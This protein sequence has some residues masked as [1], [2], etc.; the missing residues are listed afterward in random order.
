MK[1]RAVTVRPATLDDVAGIHQAHARCRNPWADPTECALYVNHRLLRGFLIDV[2]VIRGQVVGHAE[3]TLCKE[4]AGR[5]LY[6]GLIQ[7]HREHRGY[8]VGRAMMEA[9]ERHAQ[10]NR[11]PRIVTLAEPKAVGFYRSCGFR[12]DGKVVAY[13]M[14]TRTAPLPQDWRRKRTVPQAV[15]GQFSMRLGWAQA[16][17]AFMW[18]LCNRPIRVAGGWEDHPCCR[19]D[20]GLAWVQLHYHGPTAGGLVIA[21]ADAS[22]SVEE[23]VRTSQA[24]AHPSRSLSFLLPEN[25]LREYPWPRRSGCA[26][27]ICERDGGG[28]R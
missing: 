11:C 25:V 17:S 22:V 28:D 16:S 3:W 8:G 12:E 10:R 20:D 19:R 6:L 23:L 2:A 13:S 9:G 21:W 15:V 24:L 7:V 18:E 4:T 5:Y 26:G 27:V 1:S 14:R